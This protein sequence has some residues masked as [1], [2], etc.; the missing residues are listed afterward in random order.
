MYTGKYIGKPCLGFE[1]NH[2]YVFRLRHPPNMCYELQEVE[3]NLFI[4]YASEISIRQ[5]WEI[6]ESDLSEKDYDLPSDNIQP[7]KHRGRPKKRVDK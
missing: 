3:D 2:T 6:I 5:N 7:K 4:T 1:T